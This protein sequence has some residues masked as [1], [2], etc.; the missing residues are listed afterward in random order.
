M[1]WGKKKNKPEY[2]WVKY[3]YF[4]SYKF[5]IQTN[6]VKSSLPDTEVFYLVCKNLCSSLLICDS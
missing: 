1:L 6:T 3:A 5:I 4:I 2:K